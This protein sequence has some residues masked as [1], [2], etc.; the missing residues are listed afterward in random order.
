VVGAASKLF[1]YFIKNYDYDKIISYSDIRL[2]DGGMYEKLNFNKISQS[3]PNY[4]YVKNGLRYYR[5]NFRKSKLIKEGFDSNKTE[6]EI[7]FERK[8]YR[9]YDCGNIRWEYCCFFNK[10]IYIVNKKNG[11]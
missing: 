10:N 7:M 5:F 9:I 1:N 11:R 6:K 3:K 8:M 4:W 2:F